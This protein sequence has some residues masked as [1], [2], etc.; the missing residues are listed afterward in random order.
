MQTKIER[1]AQQ[2]KLAVSFGI[3]WQQAFWQRCRQD[4]LTVHA[5]YL[6]YVTLLSL[7]PMVAVVFAMFSAFPVFASI[8]D[9]VQR[10]VFN[11]FVPTSGEVIQQHIASFADNASQ[12]T[13]WG[14]GFLVLTALLL[15]A[16]ID[17]T[18]NRIWRISA[19]RKPVISF[20]IYWMVLTLGPIL[21]GASIGLTSYLVTLAAYA[22]Q[23]T[24]GFSGLLLKALPMLISLVGFLM[25][26]MLVPNTE[27]PFRA[28]LVGALFS[29]IAFELCKKGFA[30]YV[31]YF[32]S[33]ELIYGALATIPILFVW[34]YTCWMIVLLGAEVTVTTDSL[35]RLQRRS[36]SD[37]PSA[38]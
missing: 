26:Y 11:N 35:W 21:L 14:I 20:A 6:A 23:V 29:S 9:A 19:K 13:I 10:F 2:I 36:E 28:A 27:V 18:L 16:N 32:P 15:I 31:S 7:V 33:Y 22:D 37:L 25:L 1:L 4:Q 12:M 24:P 5:G 38:N 30:L 8:K 17:K 34:V 3:R